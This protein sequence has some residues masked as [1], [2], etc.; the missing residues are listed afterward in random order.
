LKRRFVSVSAA[1]IALGIIGSVAAAPVSPQKPSTPKPG[2]KPTAVKKRDT[3]KM[4]K[5]QQHIQDMLKVSAPGDEYFGRMKMS[6]L[7]INNTFH[8]DLIRA[9]AYTTDPKIISRI[10]FAD[11]AL[12]AWYKKYPN[13]PQLARSYFLAFQ[14]YRKIWVKEYQDKAWIY[15]HRVLEKWPN[16][17]FGKALKKDLSIGFTEHYF[18]DPV[19]CADLMPTVAESGTPRGGATPSA[20]PSPTPTPTPTPTPLAGGPKIEVLPVPCST[21]SPTPTP[22]PSLTP[23]PSGSLAPSPAPSGSGSPEASASPSAVATPGASST[24]SA[25]PSPQPSATHKP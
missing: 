20:S 3:P 15:S 1:A 7:G 11:E 17:F 25:V 9:G 12:A 6:Y 14:M 16:S 22:L 18:A 21:P 2:A 24:P 5:W 10:N 4:S 23:V 13:D 19:P 8:D